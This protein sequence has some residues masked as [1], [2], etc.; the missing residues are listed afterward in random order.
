MVFQA[1]DGRFGAMNNPED[2]A[3][4]AVNNPL[5]RLNQVAG[6]IAKHNLRTRFVATLNHSKDSASQVLIHMML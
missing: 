2:D 4:S 5:V 6:N 1:P 3:Q